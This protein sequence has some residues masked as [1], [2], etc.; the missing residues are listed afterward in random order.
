MQ[1]EKNANII[2]LKSTGLNRKGC[3]KCYSL[4]ICVYVRALPTRL[5]VQATRIADAFLTQ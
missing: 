2:Y 3:K 4:E 1:T 5:A